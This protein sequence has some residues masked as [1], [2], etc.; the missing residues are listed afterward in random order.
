MEKLSENIEQYGLSI[1]L[2]TTT[3]FFSEGEKNF[4]LDLF[5]FNKELKKKQCDPLPYFFEQ[6]AKEGP[7]YGSISSDY[8]RLFRWKPRNV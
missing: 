2:N 6:I 1:Y 3:F 5:F 4:G 8:V 7:Y